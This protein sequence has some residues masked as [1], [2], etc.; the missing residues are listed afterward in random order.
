M[1]PHA[2]LVLA[3]CS[4]STSKESMQDRQVTPMSS[5]RN[6]PPFADATYTVLPPGAIAI[7]DTRPPT[8][9]N[10]T[11]CPFIT[12][13]GPSGVQFFAPG[14][15]GPAGP[16]PAAPP[17]VAAAR[18]CDAALRCLYSRRRSSQTLSSTGA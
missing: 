7:P 4:G 5:E 3:N 9:G 2:R 12:T 13:L 17:N 15:V 8:G 14:T 16:K 6:T 10:P 11:A 1:A 18:A